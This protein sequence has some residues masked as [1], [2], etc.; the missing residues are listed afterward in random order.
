MKTPALLGMA[1]AVALGL[2]VAALPVRAQE[3][4]GKILV[5]L[6]SETVLPLRD[7]K[8]FATGYYLNELIIPVQKFAAAG[9]QIVFTN[10]KG[11]RPSVDPL[12]VSPDYFGGSKDALQAA[13]HFRDSL[14]GLSH[15][16]PL[17]QVASGD[18][19]QY[20]AVFVPGGP[21]P[22]ID[23]MANPALGKI[24]NYFHQHAKTT[25]LLC[26]G[27]IALLAATEHPVAEQTALRAGDLAKAGKLA[28]N[29]PYRGYKMT[30]FSNEEER[31]AI[32]NVFHTAPLIVPQQALETAGGN[33]STA[34][35]WH[36]HVVQDRELI[37][38]QNPASDAALAAQTL[39]A[40][41][42]RP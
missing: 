17:D 23:L 13:E 27:P 40:L 15:P 24:L 31:I 25:A 36:P 37:T 4:K 8:T 5:V 21:A 19:N 1:V 9:Y 26:H 30:I 11:N 38:G 32:E 29:W 41:S 22:T 39:E 33:V 3:P 16:L 28:A 10:P 14:T 20:K 34:A 18:L 42:T 2:S 6:P 35:A 12:S 7:G